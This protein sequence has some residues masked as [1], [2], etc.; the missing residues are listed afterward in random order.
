M[1]TF[2]RGE[3]NACLTGSISGTSC[4]VDWFCLWFGVLWACRSR[5][6]SELHSTP[7]G[8][9]RDL[10]QPFKYTTPVKQLM[11]YNH[12]ECKLIF[13]VCLRT[14]WLPFSK[15]YMIYKSS[16]KR[17][18]SVCTP[19]QSINTHKSRHPFPRGGFR[20][21]RSWLDWILWSHNSNFSGATF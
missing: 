4:D 8:W 12:P 18:H 1:W 13:Y 5:C 14:W 11:K 9:P 10:G 3:S 6:R 17:Q 19:G 20:D 21:H 16:D 7:L 15:W 2:Y